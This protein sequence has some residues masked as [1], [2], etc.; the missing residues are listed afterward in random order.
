M[1]DEVDPLTHIWERR[2]LI[3]Q[4]EGINSGEPSNLSK[5]GHDAM[6][7]KKSRIDVESKEQTLCSK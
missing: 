1:D 6:E 2:P 4:T 3:S 5:L 7:L